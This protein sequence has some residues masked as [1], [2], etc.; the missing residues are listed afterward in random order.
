MKISQ[1]TNA[2]SERNWIKRFWYHLSEPRT[3]ER[4]TMGEGK[5][6]DG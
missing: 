2:N 5:T 4:R 1:V 6:N 3:K